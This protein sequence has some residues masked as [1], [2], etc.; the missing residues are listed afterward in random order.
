[1]VQGF[2]LVDTNADGGLDINELYSM[3]KRSREARSS[4]SDS[5]AGGG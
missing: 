4:D 1:L 3:S 5:G 2:K